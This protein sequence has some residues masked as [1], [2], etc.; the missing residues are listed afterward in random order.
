MALGVDRDV[1][2]RSPYPGRTSHGADQRL[3]RPQV[4]ILLA[5]AG[6]EQAEFTERGSRDRGR[7]RRRRDRRAGRACS[8][9]QQR[10][11]SGET[12]TVDKTFDQVSADDYDAVIVPGARS[13][14][15]SCAGEAAAVRFVRG[16]FEAGKPAGVICH[17]AWTLV[18]ADVVRGRTLTSFL[19]WPPTSA[20]AG[21]TWVDREVWPT[22]ACDQPQPRGPARVLRQDRRRVRRG[23]AP[24]PS[25]ST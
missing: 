20:N 22:R 19:P 5:P 9:R 16:I 12:F 15:T 11:G 24:R 18:E 2:F 3:R 21:G 4:A 10:P 6:S 14:P 13:A 17:G 25:A 8:D 1:T 7:R 23:P